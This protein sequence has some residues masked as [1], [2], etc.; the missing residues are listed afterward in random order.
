MN[1]AFCAKT[2]GKMANCKATRREYSFIVEW[3]L[4]KD[5]EELVITKND[6]SCERGGLGQQDDLLA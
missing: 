5:Q 4:P 1:D 2:K 3:A 6:A